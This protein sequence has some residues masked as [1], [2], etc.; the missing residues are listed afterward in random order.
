VDL[1]ITSM[2]M[3]EL[4]SDSAA[5]IAPRSWSMLSF[6]FRGTCVAMEMATQRRGLSTRGTRLIGEHVEVGDRRSE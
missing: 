1:K 2:S 4:R 5:W 6:T 3:R